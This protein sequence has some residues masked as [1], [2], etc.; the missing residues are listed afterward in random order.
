MRRTALALAAA[1]VLA[2]P[3]AAKDF[4]PG[5]LR[6]CGARRCVPIADAAVLKQLAEFYYGPR[7]AAR[8]PAPRLGA[9]Y[10]ELRFRNGYVTGIVAGAKLDR[11]LSYGVHLEKFRAGQ[12]YAV[13]A[14]SAHEL[15]RLAGKRIV[16]L[17]LD[18][19]AL[20]KTH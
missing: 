8:T 19:A 13:P 14:A 11:F 3:A 7:P 20:A 9:P 2:V 4:D 16:P 10:L 15:R 6:L 5:D 18:R 12:W 1:F 17:V